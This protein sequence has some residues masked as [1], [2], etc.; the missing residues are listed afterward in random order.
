MY[1]EQF[2]HRVIFEFVLPFDDFLFIFLL[3]NLRLR[4]LLHLFL[5]LTFLF[6]DVLVIGL[7]LASSFFLDWL[8][9]LLFSVGSTLLSHNILRVRTILVLIIIA[10]IFISRIA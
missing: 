10:S 8:V 3:V 1:L 2:V 7:R 6:S 5:L 9:G 4:L